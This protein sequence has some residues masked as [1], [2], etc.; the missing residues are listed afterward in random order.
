[1]ERTNRNVLKGKVTTERGF[2]KKA[3]GA[4]SSFLHCPKLDLTAYSQLNV[5]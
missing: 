2:K 5:Y 1:M 3:I 4:L